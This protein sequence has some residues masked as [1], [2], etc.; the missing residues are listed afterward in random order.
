MLKS[1]YDRVFKAAESPHAPYWLA[2]VSFAESSFFPIPP[3]VMLAPMA[4]AKP[5]RAMWFAFICTIASVA[6]GLLGYAIGAFAYETIGSLII[7][8]SKIEQFRAWY[9][10]YGAMLILVKGVLPI[11][12]K[13]ITIASGVAGYNLFWFTVLCLVTRGA[14]FFAVAG[15]FNYLGP[16]GRQMIERNATLVTVLLVAAIVGGFVLIKFIG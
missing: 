6:G 16:S 2:V 11:P 4:M 5:Q 14:R 8:A 9:A 10:D 3:D 1:L 12:F 13:L 15:L 7:S